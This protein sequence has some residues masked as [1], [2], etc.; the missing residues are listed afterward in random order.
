MPKPTS[1]IL[2][3]NSLL[4]IV[5]FLFTTNIS[6]A[7]TDFTL[8]VDDWVEYTVLEANSGI[9]FFYGAWP[10]G[11]FF[12]NWSIS[13]GEYIVFNITSLDLYGINGTLLAGNYTFNDVRNI[14][15]ASALA[16]SIFPWNG[17]FFANSSDWITIKTQIENTNTTIEEDSNVRYVINTKDR[18]L[19]IIRFNTINYYGQNSTFYYD[20]NSGVLLNAKT[21][22]SNYLLNI[23][24]SKSSLELGLPSKTHNVELT[25][26]FPFAFIFL[27]SLIFKRKLW[28]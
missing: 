20:K 26:I 2:T 16:I 11:K 10:P 28:K 12:G 22:F 9:N 19:E 23:S 6:Q 24:L 27:A 4:I 3:I 13:K 1:K 15:V 5:L 21:S 14:D 25:K 7:S 17:G 8:D 18:Y